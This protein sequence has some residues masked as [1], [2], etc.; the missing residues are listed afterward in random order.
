MA[1]FGKRHDAEQE[2]LE[3]LA[4]GGTIRTALA[5]CVIGL[6]AAMAMA[7]I[8]SDGTQHL[9]GLV[10]SNIPNQ[11][12]ARVTGSVNSGSQLPQETRP[13]RTVRY[14]IRRSVM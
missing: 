8:L 1:T 2:Q 5:F 9:A 14:T 3:R 11:I 6:L 7:P 12:D 10:K 13:G 4:G